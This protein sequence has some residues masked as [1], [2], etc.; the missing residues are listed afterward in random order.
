VTA[1]AIPARLAPDETAVLEQV[2]TTG[3]TDPA[4]VVR[5]YRAR[6]V[7]LQAQGHPDQ[8]PLLRTLA[9]VEEAAR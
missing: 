9:G 1:P 6:A 7:V 5:A 2:T 4:R 8:A 3:L